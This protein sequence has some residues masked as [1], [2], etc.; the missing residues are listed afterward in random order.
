MMFFLGLARLFR[1][2]RRLAARAFFFSSRLNAALVAATIAFFAA[3][4]AHADQG[5]LRIATKPGD[6]QI[7]INGQRKGNSPS[8]EGQNFAIKLKAGEYTI[9]AVKPDGPSE[10]YGKKSV[11]VSDDT[12]QT[13]TIEMTER[14]SASFRAQLKQKYAGRPPTIDMVAIPAGSFEMGSNSYD[15]E[16]PPHR[17]EVGAFEMSKTEITFDQWDACVANGGCDHFPKDEGWGRGNRPVINV[18]WDD[19]QQFA[20][21]MSKSTGQRFRL[22]S[23]AEWEYAARAGTTTKFSTGDCIS[24]SQANYNANRPG[25]GCPTGEYRKQT[26][27]VGSFAANAFGLHDM[28]GNVWEWTQDCWNGSYSGAPTDGKAWTSGNCGQR[29]LR[30]GSW[31]INAGSARSALRN[32]VG[33]DYHYTDTGFRLSRSR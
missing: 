29:V 23:E 3:V 11:F 14:P 24:A 27:P 15:S 9:E 13:I 8:E 31:D 2:Q 6:A 28:H 22:P 26:I 25:D 4:P 16:R 19:A 5:M 32:Y 20:A 17:V 10:K 18:S 7:F 1:V 12:L 30:G 21:W 33:T